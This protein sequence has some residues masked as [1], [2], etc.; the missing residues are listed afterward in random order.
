MNKIKKKVLTISSICIAIFIVISIL[1]YKNFMYPNPRIKGNG[2]IKIS[3]VGDSI[4]YGLG[5]FY[6]KN[7]AWAS[8]LP[9]KLDNE[10]QTTNYGLSS[11]TLLS[12]GDMPY[13]KEKVAEQFWNGNEDIVIFMLGTNDSKKCNWNAEQFE[14]EYREIIEKLKA[15]QCNPKLY[16]MIPTQLFNEKSGEKN[17]DRKNLEEGVIPS[18]KKAI[19]GVSDIEVIDLYE[20]TKNHKEWFSDGIHPNKKGNEIIANEI[21]NT[22][23][24]TYKME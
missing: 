6:D 3:C 5:V 17:P 16:V 15:K 23:R 1:Q 13:M 14:K 7:E 10:Y 21:A 11:R 19:E 24:K 8:L 20:L 18:I 2:A 4:T 22:I 12:T 9:E